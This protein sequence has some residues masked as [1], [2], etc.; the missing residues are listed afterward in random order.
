[1]TLNDPLK[2]TSSEPL[3]YL[4]EFQN[5]GLEGKAP[6]TTE[7]YLRLLKQFIG[8]LSTRIGNATSFQPDQLTKTALQSY[9][10]QLEK[11]GYSLAHRQL[12]KSA[13]SSFAN[14][15]IEDKGLLIRNPTRGVAVGVQPLLAPRELSDDQ[16]YILQNLAERSA[17]RRS[18]ALF[19]LGFWAG[20]RV[21]DV[22]WLLEED[23]HLTTKSGW[24]RVGYKGGKQREL[25]LLNQVRK[26]LWDYYQSHQRHSDSAY[27]FTSQRCDRLSE[28]GIHHW[29]RQLKIHAKQTE[30]PHIQT[31]TFH[32]LRHDWA[33][34]ARAAGWNLEEIAYYLGHVTSRGQVAIATTIR[35]TQ[36]SREGV[37]A[38]LKL[39]G[40]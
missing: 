2:L 36:A 30:W 5:Y 19:A 9:L 12:V 33:H 31:V 27:F 28:A 11:Q 22:S 37:R 14:F 4:S 34:R 20:C 6:A 39:L 35:Y 38:K 17:D 7:L 23:V 25:D 10:A 24:L 1:M 32:D 16:R 3:N 40:S 18:Q 26:P 13:T 21:S 29:F 8:W 15:L